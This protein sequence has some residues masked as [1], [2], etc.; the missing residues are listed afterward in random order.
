MQSKKK[1]HPKEKTGLHA[2]N[3]HRE[4]YNFKQLIASSPDLAH[5]VSVNQYKDE[6]IDFFNPKAVKALNK[7][8]LNHFYGIKH[9]NIPNDYLCP[10]IPGR[11]DYIHHIADIVY[12]GNVDKSKAIHCIDIGTGA[13]CIYPIVGNK[14]YNWSFVGTDIDPISVQSA[15]KIVT[16]NQLEDR[17]E[18]RLQ[19]NA[20]DVYRGII[21]PED[22]FDLS[23]C[24][25]PFHSSLSEAQA[26]ASRKLSNLKQ[27]TIKRV[28]LNFGGKNN[29]LW[30]EG[31]EKRFLTSMIYQSKEFSSSCKWFSTLVSKKESVKTL[32]QVLKEVDAI[33]VQ[34]IQMNL[35]NKVS[36][37]LVWRF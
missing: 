5:Y 27:R 8:L 33:D 15:Q 6:S 10:P 21:T 28:E 1:E 7:A 22:Q 23:I 3:K 35:G 12:G 11:A 4:R 14:E 18:I 34:T 32:I 19:K 13:N 31:G 24:N 26:G 29:E 20:K 17:I 25:P 2:R 16:D 9:W 36:R 37:I 30:C